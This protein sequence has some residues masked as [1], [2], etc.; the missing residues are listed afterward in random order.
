MSTTFGA[1][2]LVGAPVRRVEDPA[3]LRGLGTFVDNLDLGADL[4]HL[5]FVRSPVAHADLR[6]VDVAAARVMPGVVGAWTAADLDLPVHTGLMV[7]DPRLEQWPL[8]KDRV[9]YVGDPVAVIAATTRTAAV[10]AAEQVVVDYEP[11]PAVVGIEH[12]L[13]AASPVLFPDVGTNVV[14]GKR[15]PDGYDP[16]A[17]ADVVVRGRFENQRIAVAP[18]EG[19]AV[20]VVPGAKGDPFALTGTW[21]ASHRTRS[22]RRSPSS[23]ASTAIRSG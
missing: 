17:G 2:S 11:L 14:Y 7:L 19:Q 18:M 16:L 21:P 12:A 3:L 4:V 10:D 6:S 1:G 22:G 23:S 9:R 13:D 8:A 5:V 20:A 15:E